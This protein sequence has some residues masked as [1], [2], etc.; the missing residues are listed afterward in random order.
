MSVLLKF[1]LFFIVIYYLLRKVGGFLF[2]IMGGTRPT[3]SNEKQYKREGEINI[4]YKPQNR[5]GKFGNDFKGGEYV[6]YEEVK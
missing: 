4:D 3:S 6:D 1:I 2:R 5:N